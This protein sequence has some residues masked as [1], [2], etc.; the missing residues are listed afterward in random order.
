MN[1]RMS[2]KCRRGGRRIP[3][4]IKVRVLFGGGEGSLEKLT[5]TNTCKS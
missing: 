2:V 1:A 4:L 5:S 3:Y